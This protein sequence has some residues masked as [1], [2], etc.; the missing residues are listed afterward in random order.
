[1]EIIKHVQWK[2][3]I[4]LAGSAD[5]RAEAI[6]GDWTNCALSCSKA[7]SFSCRILKQ[8]SIIVLVS[9]DFYFFESWFTAIASEIFRLSSTCAAF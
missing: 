1:M 8:I 9:N 4:H 5:T 3:E 2:I 6:V 7:A